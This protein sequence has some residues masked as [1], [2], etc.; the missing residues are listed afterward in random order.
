MTSSRSQATTFTDPTRADLFYHLVSG[1]AHLQNLGP[2]FAVSF[3][4]T[5]PSSPESDTIIGWIPANAGDEAGLNDF[6]ENPNF[7]RLLHTA[8]SSGLREGID[9]IQINGATQLQEGWMHIHDTRN[10]PALGR[11]G[12]P[13]D[14]LGSVLV[15]DS[16]ILADTYSPMPSYRVCTAD[17]VPKLT[18]GLAQKLRDVLAARAREEETASR[19]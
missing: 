15:Q 14:I 9:D 6:K 13:D 19:S 18:D 3:L 4:E 1:P 7:L 12:D 2:V 8:V 11:I 16:K 17:G 5:P 10:V